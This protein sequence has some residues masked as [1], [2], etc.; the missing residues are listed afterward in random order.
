MIPA[1]GAVL[2]QERRVEQAVGQGSE[3]GVQP[4]GHW[5]GETAFPAMN[6][7]VRH[8]PARGFL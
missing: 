1:T 5:H 8:Q 4:A 2:C 6:D 3:S 7:R